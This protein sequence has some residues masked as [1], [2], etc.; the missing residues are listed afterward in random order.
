VTDLLISTSSVCF[1]LY[2]L[3]ITCMFG[4]NRSA[5]YAGGSDFSFK[6]RMAGRLVSTVL[7]AP[8]AL[9]TQVC[10]PAEVTVGSHQS[11]RTCF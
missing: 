8:R 3:C 2:L 9:T 6:S 4:L 11:A 1:Y 7:A 5:T 10:T